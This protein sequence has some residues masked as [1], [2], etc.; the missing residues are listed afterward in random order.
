MSQPN[1]LTHQKVADDLSAFAICGRVKSHLEPN[2]AN[3]TDVRTPAQGVQDGVDAERLGFKRVFIA[4]RVDLKEPAVLLGGIAARTERIG[5][6]TGVIAA[7]SRHPTQLAAIGATMHAAYGP[8]FVLGLGRGAQQLAHSGHITLDAFADLCTIL[9]RLWRG[10]TVEYR[11]PAGDFG[12]MSLADVYHGDPP[13]IWYGGFGLSK[14]AKVIAETPAIDGLLL[15]VMLT[16]EAVAK[17]VRTVR[18]ACER[19]GRDP[20]SV[21]IVAEVLTA[22]NLDDDEV[23]TLAHARA[24]T[25]LQADGWADGYRALNNWDFA[26]VDQ[27]RSHR[28][29]AAIQGGLADLAF[30]RKDLRKPAELI[31]DA[32]MQECCAIGS[33]DRCVAKLREFKDAGADELTTYGSTPGQNA[34]LVAAW[35]ERS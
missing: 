20:A 26:R 2:Q 6:G 1:H 24:V 25:Y 14:G 8:R 7:A 4:E 32:W 34:E 23:H 22:P 29:F 31:P 33:V 27:M 12:E 17:S 35:T 15:P 9:K 30:H 5:L 10:E 11:G 13:E 3:E 28:Q 16:P 21:R 19:T 18:E